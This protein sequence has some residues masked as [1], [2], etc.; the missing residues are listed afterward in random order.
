VTWF[1]FLVSGIIAG[2]CGMVGASICR[3]ALRN[4]RAAHVELRSQIEQLRRSIA[5]LERQFPRPGIG[6]REME[7]IARI[8]TVLLQ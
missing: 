2:A 4:C 5:V 7:L 1:S 3:P 6:R 8:S